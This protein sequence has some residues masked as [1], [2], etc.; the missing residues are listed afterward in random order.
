MNREGKRVLQR[1]EQV[2]LKDVPVLER[3]P[4]PA[5]A[6]PVR[7]RTTPADY[8]RQ[9]REEMR[10]V[11]WPSRDELVN[12]TTVVLATVVVMIALIFVLNYG[13]GKAVLF[14]FQK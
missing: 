11:A 1:E 13:F 9:V 7:R 4:A 14:M 8:A 6:R 12:Y 3:E 2:R 5:P 10:H